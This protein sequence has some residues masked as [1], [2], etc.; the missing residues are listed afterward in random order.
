[1]LKA[2]FSEPFPEE[3]VR[4]WG[5]HLIYMKE[6]PDLDGIRVLRCGL[7]AAEIRDRY[8]IPDHALALSGISCSARQELNAE[9]AATFM[10]GETVP[11]GGNGWVLACYE[12]IGIGWG[13]AGQGTLKNHYPKGLRKSRLL[14]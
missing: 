9:S 5:T 8:L 14:P 12:G 7:Q 4:K 3:H 13:K 1:M 6:P 10:S 11:S 2:L